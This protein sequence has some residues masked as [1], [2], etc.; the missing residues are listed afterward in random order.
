MS[1]CS[2]IAFTGSVIYM[3]ICSSLSLS[4]ITYKHIGDG[5]RALNFTSPLNL[6]SKSNTYTIGTFLYGID[7]ERIIQP[8]QGIDIATL[9]RV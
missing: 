2:D 1:S 9:G 6:D 8:P 5:V 3:Y 7:G 4:H